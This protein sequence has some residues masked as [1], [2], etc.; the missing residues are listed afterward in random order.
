[1]ER[2]D[3]EE[4]SDL[5]AMFIDVLQQQAIAPDTQPRIDPACAQCALLGIEFSQR[6]L[7]A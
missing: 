1:M 6:F 2:F 4:S 3:R 7:N 5:F